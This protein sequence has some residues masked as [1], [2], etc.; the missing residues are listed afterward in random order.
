MTV[1]CKFHFIM[2]LNNL[3]TIENLNK[4]DSVFT[5]YDNK[6]YKSNFLQVFGKNP[7]L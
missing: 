7:W 5:N 6:G 4:K 2:A 3:T 1:F